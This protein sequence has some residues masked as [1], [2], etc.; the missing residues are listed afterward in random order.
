MKGRFDYAQRPIR[1]IRSLSVV[2]TTGVCR[3]QL[4]NHL[5][6]CYNWCLIKEDRESRFFQSIEKM[7]IIATSTQSKLQRDIL[8]ARNVDEL[9]SLIIDNT[10]EE[11]KE[12]FDQ[13][14]PD[15]QSKITTLYD[16]EQLC[17][18]IQSQF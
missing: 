1:T 8:A 3:T 18:Q 17:L 16:R 6:G 10:Y 14:S 12:A 15:L 4:L 9:H 5:G 2:E 11:I 13:L 7:T